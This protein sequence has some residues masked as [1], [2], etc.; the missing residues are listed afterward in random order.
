MYEITDMDH[1]GRGITRIDG[2]I[3]FV[4]GALPGEIVELDIIENKKK[5]M[6]ANVKSVKNE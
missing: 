2:K 1:F 5:Y 3:V 6:V 4:N